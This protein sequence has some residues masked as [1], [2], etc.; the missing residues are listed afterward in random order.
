MQC[1]F[2]NILMLNTKMY[3]IY[4]KENMLDILVSTN[5][6]RTIVVTKENA[7]MKR[8]KRRLS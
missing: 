6:D 4:K 7:E 3:E 1:F 5:Y 8:S 2:N